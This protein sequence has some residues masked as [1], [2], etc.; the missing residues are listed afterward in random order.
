MNG[1][2]S[3]LSSTSASSAR[4]ILAGLVL[5]H[6]SRAICG[7]VILCPFLTSPNSLNIEERDDDL[8][9]LI[10][11]LHAM[12]ITPRS[13]AVM[14]RLLDLSH[15]CLPDDILAKLI[16][17]VSTIQHKPTNLSF[18]HLRFVAAHSIASRIKTANDQKI[19]TS[20]LEALEAMV[21]QDLDVS[22]SCAVLLKAYGYLT[23]QLR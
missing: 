1:Y 21:F 14:Y 2:Q 23:T 20:T 16:S 4:R 6:Y 17:Q 15:L 22:K 10:S 13:Y 11:D 19:A 18:N 5:P 9:T 12:N 8:L 7:L 3:Y